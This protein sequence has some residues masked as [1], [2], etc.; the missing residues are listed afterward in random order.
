MA[1]TSDKFAFS[2]TGTQISMEIFKTNE[3]SKKSGTH[4][5]T[6]LPK[7]LDFFS[8]DIQRLGNTFPHDLNIFEIHVYDSV[9]KRYDIDLK[10]L[11]NELVSIMFRWVFLSKNER[12]LLIKSIPIIDN[13]NGIIAEANIFTRRTF[14]FL[15]LVRL[16]TTAQLESDK[17]NG[18]IWTSYHVHD[19]NSSDLKKLI[20]IKKLCMQEHYTHFEMTGAL[21]K[22]SNLMDLLR[23]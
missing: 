18:S 17:T 21:E 16:S 5:I 15:K 9:D 1:V 22:V 6:Q 12:A 4:T 3:G 19:D 20:L 23:I 10:P 2:R 11:W 8:G 13:Y 14:P 7:E